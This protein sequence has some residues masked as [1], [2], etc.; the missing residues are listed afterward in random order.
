MKRRRL[1]FFHSALLI[2]AITTVVAIMGCHGRRPYHHYQSV[3][4]SRWTMTDTMRFTPENIEYEGDYTVG[5][6]VR[7]NEH[8][9]YR[10][11]WLVVEQRSKK[12]PVRAHRDTVN[13][14]LTDSKGTWLTQGV[15]LHEVEET[16]GRTRLEKDEAYEFLV[17]HIMS[18]QQLEGVTDVG[19]SLSPN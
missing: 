10:N 18:N 12:G 19:L 2:I 6:G 17:Y 5:V 4:T 13:M 8:F 11:L 15:V 1:F 16:V 9:A 3:G 7:V 14:I